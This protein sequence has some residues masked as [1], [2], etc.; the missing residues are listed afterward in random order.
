MSDPHHA[1]V[2]RSDRSVPAVSAGY[3]F[4]C[5]DPGLEENVENAEDDEEEPEQEK[6]SILRE[7]ATIL[8]VKDT[9]AGCIRAHWVPQKG[10]AGAPWIAKEVAKD[11]VI[12]GHGR[13]VF[14]SDQERSI[15]AVYND[16][17]KCREPYRTIPVHSP[18]GDSQANGLIERANRSV[19]A[20][21]RT[22]VFALEGYLNVSIDFRHPIFAWIVVHAGF[23]LTH[24]EVG[25]DG[26]T[27]YERLK[28]KPM[29]INLCKFGETILFMP[30]KT[31]W[32]WIRRSSISIWGMAGD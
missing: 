25:R 9:L 21:V 6:T 19:K 32:S 5:R 24:F 31:G 3:C 2:D 12:W 14:K 4:M 10:T 8:D 11:M 1:G 15:V 7:K 29:N 27:P 16:L 20:Q 30:L 22:F 26:R 18:T 13:C 23:V 28:G 17:V